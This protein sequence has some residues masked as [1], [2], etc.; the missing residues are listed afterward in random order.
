MKGNYM[1]MACIM[2]IYGLYMAYLD[3]AGTMPYGCNAMPC[4]RAD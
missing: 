2:Y 4:L 1:Y 3:Q